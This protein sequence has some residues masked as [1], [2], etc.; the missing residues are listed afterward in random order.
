MTNNLNSILALLSKLPLA[1]G[2]CLKRSV[3]KSVVIVSALSS[4]AFAEN[5]WFDIVPRQSMTTGIVA[6]VAK[7]V[8]ARANGARL[9][10]S[11][12]DKIR[13][14]LQSD[15]AV[16]TLPLPLPDGTIVEFELVD[17]PI[18]A[19][20]LSLKYPSIRTLQGHQ[21]GNPA[22]KGRFD[23]TP[24][25]FHAMIRYDNETV[26]IDPQVRN[27][28]QRYISY[29][30]KDAEPLERLKTD[31]VLSESVQETAALRSQGIYRDRTLRTYRIAVSASGEYTEAQGGTKED[32]LAAIVTLLN[33]INQIFEMDLSIRL[34]LV[35]NNDEVIFTDPDTDPFANT[36]ED[37]DINIDVQGSR[38]GIDNFDIGHIVNTAGGGV[39]VLRSVCDDSL[40]SS[41]LTGSPRPTGDS[42]YVDY[43]AHE[44]GHQFGAYHTF[45]GTSSSCAGNRFFSSAFE[46]GSGSTV[47]GYAGICG[48]ENLQYRSDAYFH[49]HSIMQVYE[50]T[51]LGKGADCGAESVHNNASPLV[52][53]GADYVIPARTPFKLTGEAVDSDGDTL[54]YTWEQ[55]DLGAASSGRATMVDDGLRPLFRSW[56]PVASGERYLPRLEDVL[57]GTFTLGETYPTTTRELNFRL[58]VRDGIGGVE[59]D[60]MKVNVYGDA[61]PFVVQTPVATSHWAGGESHQVAWEVAGTDTTPLNCTE[62]QIDLSIDGGFNFTESLSTGT[63][64]DGEYTV[65]A[66]NIATELARVKVSCLDNIFFA[67]NEGNFTIEENPEAVVPS[68]ENQTPIA[69][70]EDS[71]REIQLSDLI[72]A[73]S[74]DKNPDD[75]TLTVNSGQNYAVENNIITPDENFAGTLTVP[76]VVTYGQLS[77]SPFNLEVVVVPVNDPPIALV[78]NVNVDAGS[79]GN[80]FDVLSNDGD[81]DEGDF[82]T[83]IGVNYNGIGRVSIANNQIIYTPASGFSGT[84]SIDYT[85]ADSAGETA[86][87]NVSV[88]VRGTV[89]TT[90]RSGSGGGA[91]STFSELLIAIGLMLRYMREVRKAT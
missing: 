10:R 5:L 44:I 25:G 73:D 23:I 60:A 14:I 61:G 54:T 33:R 51:R 29:Y 30:K 88:T 8:N 57:R 1:I 65:T 85:I 59:Y 48:E 64:N 19:E 76:V 16:K 38:I 9:L 70:A 69:F 18:V 37:L 2:G 42:F 84:D 63:A 56:S 27:N 53:A 90:A 24:H 67:I 89:E 35:A 6:K 26:F 45:N 79:V 66:P 71:S 41:G 17:S 11:D 72:V 75:F 4:G 50:F 78:D 21:V 68:I 87:A 31:T 62:V 83:V 39:A 12:I 32:G 47:M 52:D 82:I 46:P 49:I 13:V 28:D 86:T 80:Q 74:S 7:E 3:W 15:E 43:V 58:T 81:V 91:F 22:N 40:K 77:S 36:D 34:E 55:F 20:A